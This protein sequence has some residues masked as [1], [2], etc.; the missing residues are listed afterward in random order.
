MN[1]LNTIRLAV[2]ALLLAVAV[3]A[4]T[5]A[6]LASQPA[7]AATAA[8]AEAA[9]EAPAKPEAAPAE[10]EMPEMVITASYESP[11]A[12]KPAKAARK[13]WTCR[14]HVLEQGGSPDAPTATACGRF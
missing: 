3:G 2:A 9:P 14:L 8:P 4:P 13:P 6:M 12:K 7:K 5:A 11:V 10:I 1:K